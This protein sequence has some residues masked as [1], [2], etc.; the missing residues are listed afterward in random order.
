MRISRGSFV[1]NY[2]RTADRFSEPTFPFF[3]IILLRPAHRD[4]T[5]HRANQLHE[6]VV[7]NIRYT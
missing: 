4:A 7:I 3:F 5:I 2:A 1:A 6:S